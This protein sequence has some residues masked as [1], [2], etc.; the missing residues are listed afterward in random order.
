VAA[1][2]GQRWLLG[3]LAG[4]TKTKRCSDL[5]RTPIGARG[6][7]RKGRPAVGIW[8]LARVETVAFSRYHRPNLAGRGCL[9]AGM[10]AALVLCERRVHPSGRAVC[11][12]GMRR[13]RLVGGVGGFVVAAMMLGAFAP[14]V[15][16][17]CLGIV[18]A[19]FARG[20]LSALRNLPGKARLG[21]AKPPGPCRYL[22]SVASTLPGAGA[23]LLRVLGDEADEKGWWLLT[24]AS[25]ERLA[26]YYGAFG[27]CRLGL[28]VVMS[29][30]S[31]HVR[32]WR[33]PVKEA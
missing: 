12:L 11:L 7:D 1:L 19:V 4:G 8:R 25:S 30:G 13:G 3:R 20:A 18:A 5:A 23:E 2:L 22:H 9:L 15:A 17:A 10:L 21:R 33:P 14:V 27:F 6:A 16:E 31:E 32:M 29:D 26:S 24:E 28:A